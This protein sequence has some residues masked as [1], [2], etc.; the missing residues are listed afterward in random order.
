MTAPGLQL[1]ALGG[2]AAALIAL[3]VWIALQ[4]KQRNPERRE[5][6]RRQFL[7]RQGRLGDA[8]IT[9]G[10]ETAIYYNYSVQGVQ[11]TASQDISMLRHQLPAE[12]ERLIGVAN[13][14]YAVRNPANSILLCEEW[15]GLRAPAKV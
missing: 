8:F 4:V 13:M 10:T 6:H 5:R 3:A 7:N 14:K 15:S 11:Y 2:L 9:D 1:A 12:P